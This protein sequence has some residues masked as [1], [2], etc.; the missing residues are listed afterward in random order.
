MSWTSMKRRV[1]PTFPCLN[2]PDRSAECHATCEAYLDAAKRREEERENQRKQKQA[3]I[4]LQEQ[5]LF[6][7]DYYLKHKRK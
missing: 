3:D 7:R 6:R 5:T 4:L 2:C 1:D